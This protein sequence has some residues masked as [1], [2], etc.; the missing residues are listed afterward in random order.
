MIQLEPVVLERNGI[1]LEP[2]DTAHIA[3]LAAAAAD[4]ALWEL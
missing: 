3:G 1:R 2:L 4:G